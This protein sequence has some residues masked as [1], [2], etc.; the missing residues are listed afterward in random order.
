MDV[1]ERTGIDNLL[2][3]IALL[4]EVAAVATLVVGA[5]A[6]SAFFVHAVRRREGFEAA[7]HRYRVGIARSLLLAVELLVAADLIGTVV[8]EP[9]I[10]NLAVLGFIVLIR[11]FLSFSLE[12]EI[13]G[14]LPWRRHVPGRPPSVDEKGVPPNL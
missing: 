3:F 10:D 4:V 12:V 11:T 14:R 1:I 13:E 6:A 2:R 9:T 7:F 5:L 8:V